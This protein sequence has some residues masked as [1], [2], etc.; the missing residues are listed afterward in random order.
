MPHPF[1]LITKQSQKSQLTE[2]EQAAIQSARTRFRLST[3]VG[4]VLGAGLGYYLSRRKT[5]P[6]R[7]M[8]MFFNGAF[9]SSVTSGY[10]AISSMKEF[11]NAQKY[12]HIVAAMQDIR[13]EILRSKGVDPEHPE[14]GRRG[15]VPHK[16]NFEGLPPSTVEGEQAG[17]IQNE[18]G[19]FY[20]DFGPT[21]G[22]I[23]HDQSPWQQAE[24]VSGSVVQSSGVGAVNG[25]S[26][27][28]ASAWDEIR[29]ASG[30]QTSAWNTI[31]SQNQSQNQNQNQSQD[32]SQL[33]GARQY[34]DAW[35]RL[36]GSSDSGRDQDIFGRGVYSANNY[37]SDNDTS[38]SS[39][40]TAFGSS[41]LSS[42]DFPR[43]RE[44]FD[45]AQMDSGDKYAGS[46]SFST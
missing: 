19:S 27:Q 4:G 16:P 44:D 13:N 34:G 2:Q 45:R 18:N 5:M 30:Q 12:P 11:S 21:D 23:V 31:R 14:L 1:E 33:G 36:G 8:M 26:G 43:S 40:N 15:T 17:G 20:S 7:A 10:S 41:M 37:D 22:G 28:P 38:S 3:A 35:G 9:F 6:V 46:G 32:Q 39:S 25:G 29:K 42:E 24:P